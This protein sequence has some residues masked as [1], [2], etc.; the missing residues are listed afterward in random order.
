MIFQS[1]QLVVLLAY[2]YSCGMFRPQKAP[3]MLPICSSQPWPAVSYTGMGL[4]GDVTLWRCTKLEH[5]FVLSSAVSAR[6]RST[7][8]ANISKKIQ[9]LLAAFS[10]STSLSPQCRTLSPFSA[11]VRTLK[12]D[13]Q[14]YVRRVINNAC[15]DASERA[16][17]SASWRP[18]NGWRHR[19]RFC[20]FSSLH[21]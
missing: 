16:L 4:N 14:P 17:R 8:T 15:I 13:C 11:D 6:P 20:L 1:K 2:A 3:W 21:N 9:H 10:L 12:L 7:N 19:G 18:N 5:P